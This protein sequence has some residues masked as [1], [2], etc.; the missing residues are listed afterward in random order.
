[1]TAR[2][3]M[4]HATGVLCNIKGRR[5]EAVHMTYA[6]ATLNIIKEQLLKNDARRGAT[7]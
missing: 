6:K 3:A 2:F 5:C 4:K 7:A 1:M